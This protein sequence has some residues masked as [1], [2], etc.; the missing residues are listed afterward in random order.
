MSFFFH[1]IFCSQWTT[2]IMCFWPWRRVK[3]HENLTCSGFKLSKCEKYDNPID[4]L[5]SADLMRREERHKAQQRS[6]R[7]APVAS[8]DPTVRLSSGE[9]DAFNFDK[10]L[11][12]MSIVELV[13]I[14][15]DNA[16]KMYPKKNLLLCIFSY[17]YS[18]QNTLDGTT[19]VS[20]VY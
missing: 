13:T 17:L 12:I 16:H 18:W 2:A 11:V 9:F 7:D 5:C 6:D 10:V 4:W 14:T 19:T 3:T 1:Y 15:A 8:S 20:C